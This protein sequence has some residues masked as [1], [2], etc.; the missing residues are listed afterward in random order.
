MQKRVS[1]APPRRPWWK[2]AAGRAL[3]RGLAWRYRHFRPDSEPPRWARVAGLRLHVDRAV[4][5]PE[6]HFTS[7]F[8]AGYLARPGVVSPG[9]RVL[10]MG[11]GSGVGAI[12]AARA[13]AGRVVA[14]DINPAAVACAAGNVRRYG[15]AGRVDVRAGD[16]FAPVAGEQFDLILCNPPYF[17]GTPRTLADAAFLGGPQYEWLDRFAAKAGAHLAPGGRILVVLGDAADV[18]ALLA[19]LAAP[20]WRIAEVA[21]R[22]LWMEM[23]YIY[24][25][26]PRAEAGG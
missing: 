13:G 6:M 23:L 11:T 8:L 4:F 21:R 19:R 15:L 26:T 7:G 16:L 18:P 3:K 17:R 14:V 9:G 2:H 25:L 24:A 20:G 1:A 12:A 22:D 5:N 10:D